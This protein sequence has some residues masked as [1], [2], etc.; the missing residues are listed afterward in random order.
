MSEQPM[1]R[2]QDEILNEAVKYAQLADEQ[3]R[4]L[5]HW[6]DTFSTKWEQRLQDAK[7]TVVAKPEI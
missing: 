7:T 3:A 4:A 2:E 6:G 1:T 5:N